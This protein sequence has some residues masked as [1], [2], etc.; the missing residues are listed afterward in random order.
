MKDEIRIGAIG[1]KLFL[2]GFGTYTRII[3]FPTFEIDD[4]LEMQ[5]W[6]PMSIF[7]RE[8]KLGKHLTFFNSFVF[9]IRVRSDLYTKLEMRVYASDGKLVATRI[10]TG[11]YYNRV[12]PVNLAKLSSG[13]YHLFIYNNENGLVKKTFSVVINR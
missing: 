11:L 5:M 1:H 2:F 7:E 9:N 6:W 3:G 10:F 8:S 12:V 13:V 4:D